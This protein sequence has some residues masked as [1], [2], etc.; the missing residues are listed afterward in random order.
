MNNNENNRPRLLRSPAPRANRGRQAHVS[1]SQRHCARNA[2]TGRR[3][4]DLK[5]RARCVRNNVRRPASK[6]VT[7]LQYNRWQR[8]GKLPDSC[9]AG[10][11]VAETTGSSDEQKGSRMN[12]Q[13]CH[14]KVAWLG[15]LK[16]GHFILQSAYTLDHAPH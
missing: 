2:L 16:L 4:M 5:Q 14:L 7:Q 12:Q 10:L 1:P 6:A 11:T 8:R 13:A 3:T 9:K 15:H